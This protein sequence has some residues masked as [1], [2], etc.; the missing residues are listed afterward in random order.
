[1]DASE[2]AQCEYNNFFF[3]FAFVFQR[4]SCVFI[5]AR[6]RESETLRDAVLQLLRVIENLSLGK[7]ATKW[8]PLLLLLPL[9]PEHNSLWQSP[10][11]VCL[12][13]IL[14]EEFFIYFVCVSYFD[15]L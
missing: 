1:M 14:P 10:S 13:P 4:R 8:Q 12:S 11:L 9:Y 7:N 6:G 3:T 15:N 5:E 2:A